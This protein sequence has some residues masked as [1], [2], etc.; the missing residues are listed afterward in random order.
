L[1]ADRWKRIE[2]TFHAASQRPPQER[3]RYLDEVCAGDPELRREVE[4][5]LHESSAAGDFMAPP[6]EGISLVSRESLE[7]R[8]LNQYRI[9]RLVD[10]GGMADVYG[11]RDMKLQRDV[12]IKIVREAQFM[13]HE[14][15]ERMYRE[16]R[17]L[18]TLNHPNI[19]S[20]YG[21]EEADGVCGLILEFVD[22]ETLAKRIARAPLPVQAALGIA[23]QIA[24]G[25]Q[26]AHAKGIIH[27]DLKPSNIKLTTGATVKIIDF[28][29]AKLLRR[30]ADVEITASD[31]SFQGLVVGTIAY[32]SPEQA[33]GK[34]VDAR[35]DIWAFGCVLYEML[36]GKPAFHGTTPTDI[37]IKIATED[38][39]WDD[40][41]K[42]SQTVS[43]R[44]EDLIRKCL[45]KDP[46]GRYTSMDE[47]I[48]EL[49]RIDEAALPG[50]RSTAGPPAAEVPEN[51]FVLPMRSAPLVFL[52]AQIGYLC[53]YT[54]TMYYVDQVVEILE[55]DFQVPG[56][57]GLI[58]T[59]TIILAMCGV[60]VRVYLISSVGWR[61]PA[62]G[63]KFTLLFPLLLILDGIWAA[64]PLLVW[65]RIGYGLAFAGVAMMAYV[66]FAQRTLIRTIYPHNAL[67]S[68]TRR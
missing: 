17:V 54:A 26:A 3:S 35:T 44:L 66:P 58:G 28:G 5:L 6:A 13:N 38:P 30:E 23:T 20:I 22:G 52:L 42:F 27:R 55:R 9:G 53:L 45:R 37:I 24:L 51:E 48:T 56:G 16:A 14:R 39:N 47:I 4:S 34:P 8:T 11:A 59:V 10:S 49:K 21:I 29:I 43:Q 62:A 31:M 60:A 1:D 2:E 32:M 57:G 46:A 40:M 36:A 33:R 63:R 61:H 64:A 18:A 12:A 65:R 41:P 50:A 67:R 7:G 15:R 68:R 25:V 19:G